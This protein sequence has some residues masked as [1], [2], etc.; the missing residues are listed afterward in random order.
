MKYTKHY[1][2]VEQGEYPE[3]KDYVPPTWDEWFMKHVYLAA[4][5]SKDPRTKIGAIL[6]KDKHIISTGFN[7]FPQGVIDT[8]ERYNDR[9][10]KY[11]FVAHAEFNCIVTAAKFGISTNSSILYTNGIPCC[12]CMKSVIQSGIKE[13]VVHKQWPNMTHVEKWVESNK[14]SMSMIEESQTNVRW[15][16]CELNMDGY[17]D[18]KVI[19]V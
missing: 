3:F 13:I 8:L 7:G 10:L 12:E 17:L 19:R 11:L 15:L 18:G 1:P 14:I 6:V 16:D 5:K 9:E 2:M 4:E